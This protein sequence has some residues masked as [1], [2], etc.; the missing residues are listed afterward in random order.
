MSLAPA[1]LPGELCWGQESCPMDE[2]RPS[3]D[4]HSSSLTVQSGEP[5]ERGKTETLAPGELLAERFLIEQL[6]G[7]GG[8]GSV[9]RARDLAT[10]DRVAIK[11]VGTTSGTKPERF[12]REVRSLAQIAHPAVV[13]YVSHGFTDRQLPYL[14]MEWLEGEDLGARLDRTGLKVEEALALL[15]RICAG[16]AVAHE[17]GLI[18]RDLKPSNLF[19]VEGRPE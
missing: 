18:H 10:G 17:S 12:A 15:R 16:L 1:K 2:P 9:Y 14:A 4:A 13:R 8:M 11:V 19:L 6:A 5:A 3:Q 7:V